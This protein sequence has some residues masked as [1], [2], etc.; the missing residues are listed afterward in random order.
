MSEIK[1]KLRHQDQIVL[2]TVAILFFTIIL[3]WIV[4]K[5]QI[6][7]L[8]IYTK[9]ILTLLIYWVLKALS[10]LGIEYIPILSDLIYSTEVLCRPTNVYFPFICQNDFNNISF[11]DLSKASTTWNV[12]LIILTLPYIKKGYDRFVSTYPTNGFNKSMNLEEFIVEQT[13]NHPHLQV[14]GTLDVS[15]F[16]TEEGYFKPL[17][18]T[19]EFAK[20]HNLILGTK[21]RKVNITLG[22]VSK[23]YNDKTEE[24]PIIDEEKFLAIMR[25]QLGSLWVMPNTD[26]ISDAEKEENIRLSIE[27]MGKE[28]LILMALY[29]PVACATDEDMSEDEYKTIK[30][31]SITLTNYY[32]DVATK[33]IIGN[34]NFSKETEYNLNSR[35]LSGFNFDYLRKR[36]AK[37]FNYPVAQKIFKEHS[38]VRTILCEVIITARTLGVMPPTDIRWLKLFNRTAYAFLQNIGRPSWFSEGMG[39]LAHYLIERKLSKPLEEPDFNLALMGYEYELLSFAMTNARL[40][41]AK[42]RK[43]IISNLSLSD[44][45]NAKYKNNKTRVDENGDFKYDDDTEFSTPAQEISQE[46]I[47]EARLSNDTE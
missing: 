34:V 27:G 37:Y 40:E 11:R 45:Q 17:D 39:P 15:E 35:E 46:A 22:G 32:W 6:A 31:E 1:D 26:N 7:G 25:E 21:L 23:E 20:R 4:F 38:Y 10:V 9:G 5:P 29:L 14:F 28:D 8:Y 47:R 44:E 33:I 12:I 16:D 30:A 2:L 24:V 43:S 41:A 36:V 13:Q 19:Y 18:T 42:G 3:V